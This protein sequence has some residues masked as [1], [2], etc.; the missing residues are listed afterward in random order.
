MIK[1][2]FTGEITINP[3]DFA[4]EGDGF[5]NEVMENGVAQLA[6]EVVVE[7]E[8][9]ARRA[10]YNIRKDNKNLIDSMA[11]ILSTKFSKIGNDE[12]SNLKELSR[13]NAIDYN[14]LYDLGFDFIQ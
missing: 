10:D 13:M 4:V 9:D 12:I 6:N 1:V 5:W 14:T 11:T 8:I 7:F 3:G 2:N